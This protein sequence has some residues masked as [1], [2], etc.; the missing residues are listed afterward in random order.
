[1]WSAGHYGGRT[2]SDGRTCRFGSKRGGP[3][4][5]GPDPRA[6][7]EWWDNAH[8][9]RLRCSAGRWRPG[10]LAVADAGR[11]PT[12]SSC[13]AGSRRRRLR[14]AHWEAVPVAYR[15]TGTTLV[16]M[17]WQVSCR[18]AGSTSAPPCRICRW[19]L[20]GVHRRATP[21]RRSPGCRHADVPRRWLM[22]CCR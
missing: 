6:M 9:D 4:A 17:R 2:A 20:R 8:P 18:K 21:G 3:A 14:R 1:M 13:A 19:P 15:S 16:R 12:C 22:A 11:G 5:S 7:P 10:H